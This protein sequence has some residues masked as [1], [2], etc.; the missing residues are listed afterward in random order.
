V[1]IVQ[2]TAVLQLV[3]DKLLATAAVQAIVANR[4]HGAFAQSSDLGTIAKPALVVEIEP[5]GKLMYGGSPAMYTVA[6]SG[7]SDASL[8]DAFATYEAAC[9]ALHAEELC[10]ATNG[11]RG[12]ASEI[13]RPSG[14]WYEAA[15]CWFATGRYRLVVVR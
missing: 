3:V 5:G 9:D 4:V 8:V 10:H 15:A 6:L 14:G 11:H 7:L 12:T 1:N 13:A 2:T